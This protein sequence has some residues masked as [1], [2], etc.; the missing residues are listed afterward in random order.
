MSAIAVKAKIPVLYIILFC[1][2]CQAVGFGLLSSVSVS[3]V[4]S[5]AQFGYQALAALGCGANMTLLIVLSPYLVSKRDA[6]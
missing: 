6:G 4:I 5:K 3:T 1:S 2:V